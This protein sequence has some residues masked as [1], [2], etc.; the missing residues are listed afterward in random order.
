MET[1]IHR[2]TAHMTPHCEARGFGRPDSGKGWTRYSRVPNMEPNSDAITG[3]L[4]AWSGGD[5]AALERLIPLVYG[6]LRSLAQKHFSREPR[7]HT[8]QPTALIHELYVRLAGQDRARW[9]NRNHFFSVAAKIMRRI[10]VDHARAHQTAKRGHN[11]EPVTLSAELLTG[12]QSPIEVLALNDVLERLSDLDPDQAR[13]VELRYFA[14]LS[15]EETAE[16]MGTSPATVKR[17]WVAAKAWLW[18]QLRPR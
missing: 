3:H 14:G 5:P 4:L 15:I 6:E 12:E 1:K 18:N 8:L 10:L 11:P 17:E 7:G 16:V 9:Q 13:V 2:E